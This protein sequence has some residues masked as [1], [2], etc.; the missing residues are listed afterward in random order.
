VPTEEEA[1]GV[2]Y[3]CNM[4]VLA[5]LALVDIRLGKKRAEDWKRLHREW[6]GSR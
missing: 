6:S 1:A 4:A 2:L 5:L 3:I